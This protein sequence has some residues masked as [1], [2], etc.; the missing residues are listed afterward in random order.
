MGSTDQKNVIKAIIRK[1]LSQIVDRISVD[2]KDNY[3]N[4]ISNWTLQGFDKLIIAHMVFVSSYESKSGNMFQKIAR[5]I[6]KIRYGEANVP[7]VFCGA[8]VTNKE[9]EEF[10]RSYI[11]DEQII[12]SKIN[13]EICQGFVSNFKE[14]HIA[15]G[16]GKKKKE[17]T[18]SQEVLKEIN[19]EK[20]SI[21]N[22]IYSKPVD[23]IIYDSEKRIYYFMEIK[24]GGGLDSSNAPANVVKMLTE[25]AMA[26][27][28]S[29]HSFFATLYNFNGE[30]NSWNGIITKYLPD[31]MLLI[32]KDFWNIVLPKGISFAD[33]AEFYKEVAEELDINNKITSLIR[34]VK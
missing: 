13:P 28:N 14:T 18:L 9:F 32:G 27:S 24:A 21:D 22:K 3:A 11:K 1:E 20:F 31:E 12:I 2:F 4:K 33:L 26:K 17:S 25:Y 23:L 8:G 19:Q 30:G 16:K 34:D 6:A 5:D 15:R 7:Q 29:I 10:K